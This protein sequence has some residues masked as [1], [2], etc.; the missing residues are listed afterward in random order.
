MEEPWLRG[1]IEGVHPL[2]APVL[3]AFQQAREDLALHT[4]GL[5]PEQIWA[6]L[7]GFG[8]LGFHLRH[9]AGSTE[10]LVTYLRGRQLTAEQL[11]R[12]GAGK[13][14]GA[15]RDELLAELNRAFEAAE[16]VVRSI[17]AATLAE[18]REV[19]RKRLPTTV[20]GLLTHVAEHTQRHVGQAIAAAKLTRA[21]S[22]RPS[23]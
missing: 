7:Y 9:I 5:T 20:I 2:I 16:L 6:S 21:V 8:P 18:P 14:P 19:G 4:S 23:I 13:S 11:A 1:P 17:D 3:Y 12:A 10:R 15:D 22:G